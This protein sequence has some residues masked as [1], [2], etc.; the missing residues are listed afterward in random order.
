M[1]RRARAMGGVALLAAVSG[2]DDDPGVSEARAHREAPLYWVG[3]SFEG[4]PLTRIGLSELGGGFTYGSCEPPSDEGGCAPPLQ[5]QTARMCPPTIPSAPLTGRRTLRGVP[6]G[7][8]GGGLVLLSRRV[9]VR[10]FSA[11]PG[12]ALR[13]GAALHSPNPDVSGAAGP[14]EP[15]PQPPA[16]AERRNPCRS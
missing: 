4:L 10:I 9:E 12:L 15:L 3:E 13:A 5:I 8:R 11:D 6:A 16:D 7:Y 2:C 1:M 14:D